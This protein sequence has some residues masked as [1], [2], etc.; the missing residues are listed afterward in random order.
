MSIVENNKRPQV[1]LIA[2]DLYVERV[3]NIKRSVSGGG[4]VTHALDGWGDKGSGDLVNLALNRPSCSE[5][6]G[7]RRATNSVQ[8][9]LCFQS[10]DNFEVVQ[11]NPGRFKLAQPSKNCARLQKCD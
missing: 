4:A 7:P 8:C 2:V 3:N 9:S 1:G 11:G 5:Q 6:A 10:G